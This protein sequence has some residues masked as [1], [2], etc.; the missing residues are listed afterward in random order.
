MREYQR[1]FI[2]NLKKYRHK[3][4]L[5]QAQLSELCDVAAGTIGNIECGLSKPS[6]DLILTLATV[7]EIH[8]SRLFLDVP[9]QASDKNQTENE[10]YTLLLE[11]YTKLRIYFAEK[12]P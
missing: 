7:L 2:K 1:E 4:K 9:L 12:N 10:Q 8:P 3:K 5:S 6:F 11:F